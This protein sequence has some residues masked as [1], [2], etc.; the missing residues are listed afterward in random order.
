[1]RFQPDR[2][3]TW[4][5]G[6]DFAI[7]TEK[8]SNNHGFLN[9][10]DYSVSSG[11]LL[12]VIGDSYVEAAQVD[13]EDALHGQLAAALTGRAAVY[14]FGTSYSQLPTYLAYT[15][16][17][18]EHFGPQAMVFVLVGNDFDLDH[19]GALVR[20]DYSPSLVKRVARHSAL[21]RYL[22]VNLGFHPAGL[23][24]AMGGNDSTSFVGNT[25][26]RIGPER[27]AASLG[28]I[29]EFFRQLPKRT[30]LDTAR[31]L[32]VL[33]G[34]RPSLYSAPA[35]TAAQD[36]YFSRMRRAVTDRAASI[37]IEVVDMQSVF[38]RHFAV[39]GQPLS[40]RST[41]GMR[42]GTDSSPRRSPDRTWSPGSS[43]SRLTAMRKPV[44]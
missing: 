16:Y 27:H 10:L 26:A 25:R 28:A 19:P 17:A 18:R 41:T 36:S 4:S 3:F 30:G 24:A 20:S 31:I 14:S 1:M 32:I 7:R 2:E 38:V 37:G 6:W 5:K 39:H 12:A 11:P 8:R 44:P 29:D 9:R 22:F 42:S 34:M 33:D 15:D 40:T 13:D 23:L 35:L 43:H 21:C